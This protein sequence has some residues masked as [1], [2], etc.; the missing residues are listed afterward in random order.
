MLDVLARF[1]GWVGCAAEVVVAG[2]VLMIM[3]W[4]LVEESGVD[5]LDSN[6]A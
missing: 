3:V 2:G 4:G 1:S 6:P 5:H